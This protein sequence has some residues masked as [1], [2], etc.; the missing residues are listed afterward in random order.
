MRMKSRNEWLTECRQYIASDERWCLESWQDELVQWLIDT[1]QSEYAAK[2]RDL[3][4]VFA[5]DTD[6]GWAYEVQTNGLRVTREILEMAKD[7]HNRIFLSHSSADKERVRDYYKTLKQLGFDP[8]LDEEAMTAG[9]PLQRALLEGMKTSMA[10]VFFITPNFRDKE[11]LSTEVDYAINEKTKRADGFAI[12]TL[13]LALGDAEPDV[14]E[15]L[16][17]FVWRKPASDLDGL[18]E[19]LRALPTGNA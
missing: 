18:R 19:I 7:P 6:I 14:P 2:V 8:W 10:A 12:I 4:L 11:Y 9:V 3:K 5:D 17:C 13:V 16:Q 1:K 15:L